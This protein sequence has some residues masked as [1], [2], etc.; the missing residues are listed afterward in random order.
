MS[1]AEPYS[2]CPILAVKKLS[3]PFVWVDNIDKNPETIN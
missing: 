1:G 2:M 3:V